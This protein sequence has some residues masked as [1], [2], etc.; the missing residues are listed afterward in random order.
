MKK[1]LVVYFSQS[2]QLERLARSFMAPLE[3]DPD[4]RVHWE[5]LRPVRPYPF[6]WP[7]YRFFDTFPEAVWLDPPALHP[8]G[9]GQDERFDLIVLAHTVWYLSPSLPITGFLKSDHGRRVLKDT[10]VVTLIGC[11]NM[12]LMAQ[13]RTKQLLKEAGAHLIDNVV[14]VDQGNTL[15]TLFT[16]PYWMF[17]GNKRF[18]LNLFRPAGIAEADIEGAARFGRALD[19]ALRTGTLPGGGP[20]LQGLKAVQ[21]DDRLIASER[22]ALR[23][24]RIWGRLIRALGPQGNWKRVPIV[25]L[26]VLILVALLVTVVPLSMV[27]RMLLRPLQRERYARLKAEFELPSGSGEDRMNEFWNVESSVH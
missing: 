15:G 22:I 20:V 25:S 13:E 23:S 18:P 27:L 3:A 6:P 1:V 11:R 17:T 24:F 4:V 9:F 19:V 12:W 16:T 14:L 5:A 2:G 7:I 26:Y 8:F 10:P 21:V